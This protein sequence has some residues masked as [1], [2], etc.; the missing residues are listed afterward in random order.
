MFCASAGRVLRLP[1][2]TTNT[3]TTYTYPSTCDQRCLKKGRSKVAWYSKLSALKARGLVSINVRYGRDPNVCILCGSQQTLW[4]VIHLHIAKFDNDLYPYTML[5][6]AIYCMAHS[7]N[8]GLKNAVMRSSTN[9]EGPYFDQLCV[10][11]QNKGLSLN[12]ASFNRMW[13]CI[14][15]GHMHIYI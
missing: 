4:D 1:M 6:F 15:W 11:V 13:L 14:L 3:L 2:A 10:L 8:H 9:V 5:Q 12:N 7:D